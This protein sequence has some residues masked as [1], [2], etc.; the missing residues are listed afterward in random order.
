MDLDTLK[1]VGGLLLWGEL[2][3]WYGYVPAGG[4]SNKR[5]FPPRR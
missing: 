3:N 1:N 2:F 5:G 4:A